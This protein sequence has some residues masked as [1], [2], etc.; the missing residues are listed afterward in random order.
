MLQ[1]RQ[2]MHVSSQGPGKWHFC[3]IIKY[4]CL[5]HST[6]SAKLF[7]RGLC[8]LLLQLFLRFSPNL[9]KWRVIAWKK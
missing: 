8:I 2:T 5:F 1:T 4:N 7:I 3:E 6:R 9:I